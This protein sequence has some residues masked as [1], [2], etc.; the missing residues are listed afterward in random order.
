MS[1][2]ELKKK[3][4]EMKLEIGKI[5][6]DYDILF[7]ENEDIYNKNK[8]RREQ[9]SKIQNYFVDQNFPDEFNT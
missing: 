7:K 9:F 1:I 8:K 6:I 4:E 5:Q 2:D 3:I